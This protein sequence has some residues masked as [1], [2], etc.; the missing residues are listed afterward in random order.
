[1]PTGEYGQNRDE[2]GHDG[3]LIVNGQDGAKEIAITSGSYEESAEWAESRFNDS[4]HAEISLTGVSFSGSFEFD[5][6]SE[7]L[8]DALYQS[9]SDG[10]YQIPVSPTN[11][12]IQF[13]EEVDNG[14]GGT[15]TRTLIFKNV[16]I[17]TRSR[18]IP[19]DDMTSTSYDFVA[20]RMYKQ[21]SGG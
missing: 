15:T 9:A 5:G 11:V 19:A 13:N 14:S 4:F 10:T 17:E 12:E 21:T 7:D 2:T 3:S 6:S 1:M 16:G 18:D 20:E 8:R